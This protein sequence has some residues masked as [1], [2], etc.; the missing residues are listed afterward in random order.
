MFSFAEL[1]SSS[2]VCSTVELRVR[3]SLWAYRMNDDSAVDSCWSVMATIGLAVLRRW[4]LDT[5]ERETEN[6]D[7][8]IGS[9]YLIASAF[10]LM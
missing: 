10:G 1:A 8:N 6:R 2:M 3:T 7:L 4:M 9:P 5:N